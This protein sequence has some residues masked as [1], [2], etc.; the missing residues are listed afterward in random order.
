MGLISYIRD[1]LLGFGLVLLGILFVIVG[2]LAGSMFVS[3]IGSVVIIAGA[4]FL[5]P[6]QH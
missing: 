4:Y 3:F 5:K 6:E 1:R 2:L